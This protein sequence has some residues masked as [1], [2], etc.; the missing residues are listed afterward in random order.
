GERFPLCSAAGPRGCDLAVAGGAR[1]A[2]R[3]RA[4]GI[5]RWGGERAVRGREAA[6]PR[7]LV[8]GA[9][10]PPLPGDVLQRCGV[11]LAGRLE[12]MNDVLGMGPDLRLDVVVWFDP[13]LAQEA[14]VGPSLELAR[15]RPAT[16]LVL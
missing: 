3:R 13:P 8:V 1:A 6:V 12:S 10:D 7:L 9:A 15:M 5:R 16:G 11:T 14:W 2:H 4:R